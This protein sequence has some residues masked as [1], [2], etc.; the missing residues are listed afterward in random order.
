MT[1][2]RSLPSLSKEATVAHIT[3]VSGATAQL[4]DQRTMKLHDTEK[5][6]RQFEKACR[7]N[8]IELAK[9]CFLRGASLTEPLS[10]GEFPL[11]YALRKKHF[12]F[13]EF[14]RQYGVDMN[15]RDKDGRA[16]LHI[17][18]ADNDDEAICRLIELG[19]KRKLKDRKGQTALHAAAAAGHTKVVE[20]LLNLAA[21][22]N[23]TDKAGWTAVSHAEFNDH[24]ELADR[25]IQLGG[26]D[27]RGM[28]NETARKGRKS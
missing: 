10:S 14:L 16:A 19:A 21:E 17:A 6:R 15:M 26:S 25:L 12:Q 13:V 28:R 3:G 4:A 27:P 1:K 2:Q 7:S 22:I 20:L 24:F 11:F 23:T 8:D 9:I 5:T 18:A